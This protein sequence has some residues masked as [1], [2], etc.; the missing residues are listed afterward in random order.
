MSFEYEH[1]DDLPYLTSGLLETSEVEKLC[2]T[3]KR[4]LT[5]RDWEDLYHERLSD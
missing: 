1:G 4:T 5:Q 3:S 2:D